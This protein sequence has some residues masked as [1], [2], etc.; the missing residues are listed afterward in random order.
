MRESILEK[1]DYFIFTSNKDLKIEKYKT[2][3]VKIPNFIFYINDLSSLAEYIKYFKNKKIL[4][5]NQND[6][7]LF[8]SGVPFSPNTFYQI[9]Q[10]S[11]FGIGSISV[12]NSF[13]HE[14]SNFVFSS[15]SISESDLSKFHYESLYNDIRIN[16]FSCKAQT[17]IGSLMVLPEEREPEKEQEQEEDGKI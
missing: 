8:Y 13:N 1:F 11:S 7:L 9:E 4:Y 3:D 2:E 16:N 6:K 17:F 10:I 12:N 14:L 15:S 5:L